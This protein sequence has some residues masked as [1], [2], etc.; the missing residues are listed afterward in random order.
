MKGTYNSIPQRGC[1]VEYVTR[2]VQNYGKMFH[3]RVAHALFIDT[4]QLSLNAKNPATLSIR[5]QK[6]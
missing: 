2:T 6:S 1:A 3:I 5:E 4:F